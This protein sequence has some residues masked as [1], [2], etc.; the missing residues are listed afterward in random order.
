MIKFVFYCIEILATNKLHC[1]KTGLN[2]K[3]NKTTS[4]TIQLTELFHL[5]HMSLQ[6]EGSETIYIPTQAFHT[7]HRSVASR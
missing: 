6:N 3:N 1:M 5:T 4:N 7:F 2:K